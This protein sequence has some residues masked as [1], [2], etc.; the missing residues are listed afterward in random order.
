MSQRSWRL[1]LLISFTVLLIAR[2]WHFVGSFTSQLPYMDQ[3]DVYRGYFDNYNGWQMFRIQ[4]GSHRQGLGA[5]LTAFLFNQS[6]M[7]LLW[8]TRAMVLILALNSL[9]ALNLS[10]L[11][12]KSLSW[13]DFIVPVMILNLSQYEVFAGAPNPAHGII[14]Q[15]LILLILNSFFIRS[16]FWKALSFCTLMFCV[17]HTGYGYFAVFSALIMLL[18]SLFRSKF[19]F[20]ALKKWDFFYLFSVILIMI[21]YYIP[22][23]KPMD[24]AETQSVGLGYLWKIPF[25]AAGIVSRGLGASRVNFILVPCLGILFYMVLV[26]IKKWKTSLE[27]PKD[28]GLFYLMLTCFLFLAGAS[29]GRAPGGMGY[30]I[31]S[32]YVPY[33]TL[34]LLAFYWVLRGAGVRPKLQIRA[35]WIFTLFFSFQEFRPRGR[36]QKVATEY[37][38]NKKRFMEC[39]KERKDFNYCNDNVYSIYPSKISS[40]IP[41]RLKLMEEKGWGFFGHQ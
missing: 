3:W 24:E 29:W 33:V 18:V 13:W 7:N 25:F 21:I 34:F 5:L 14:P 4:H 30:S 8:E 1:I 11:F 31:T 27:T 23:S 40:H 6:Q 41:G 32:R 22:Y 16:Q 39:Y 26:F 28:R 36:D 9:L 38:E 2:L 15:F 12:L 17:M 19:S 10:R 35:L 20:S 37:F